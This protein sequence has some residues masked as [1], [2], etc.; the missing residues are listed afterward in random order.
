M[1]IPA[2]EL[3]T[4][5]QLCVINI[6]RLSNIWL[7]D[8]KMDGRMNQAYSRLSTTHGHITDCKLVCRYWTRLVV[9]RPAA[10]LYSVSPLKHHPTGKQWCPNPDHYSDS[11]PARRSLT[12]LCRALSRA[13]NFNVFCL[14][15]PGIEPTTSRMQGERSTTTLT[16]R[17]LNDSKTWPHKQSFIKRDSAS[18]NNY[19]CHTEY[20]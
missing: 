7:N 12:L 20:V 15:R 11:E 2:I 9:V 19:L 13:S 1:L 10:S 4:E 14:T 6:F 3:I 8:S 5:L 18:C 16:G 17:G